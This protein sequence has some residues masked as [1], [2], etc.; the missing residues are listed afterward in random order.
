MIIKVGKRGRVVE[1][2]MEDL[3]VLVED[4]E[5]NTGGYLILYCRDFDF[6]SG[7]RYDG[8]VEKCGL[9]GYFKAAKL[10]VE[11]LE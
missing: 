7:E 3:Y 5:K 9:E 8:W 6:K 10:K 11:W 1:G 2:N 4:D